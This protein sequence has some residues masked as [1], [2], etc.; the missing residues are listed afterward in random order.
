[1]TVL[2]CAIWRRTVWEKLVDVSEE[3][4][5]STFRVRNKQINRSARS[6]Q[7][8]EFL[9]ASF[10]LIG[11]LAYLSTLKMEAV[12]SSPT[13]VYF[14]QTTRRPILEGR[15]L[16]FGTS[17]HW[18]PLVVNTS[19]I[20]GRSALSQ[21]NRSTW[22]IVGFFLLTQHHWA[23]KPEGH[24]KARHACTAPA[25]LYL[26]GIPMNPACRDLTHKE[27]FSKEIMMSLL[28]LV[29]SR[30]IYMLATFTCLFTSS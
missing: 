14:Y 18:Y 15:T 24:L 17:L 28:I 19:Q 5:A 12:Y 10:L 3:C 26:Y 6:I 7:Q 22:K 13:S 20:A 16:Q 2:S 29:S 1:V 11:C 30:G 27:E 8:G 9:A 23:R 21:K 4:P 25:W